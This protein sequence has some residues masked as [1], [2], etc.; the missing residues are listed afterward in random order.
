[1]V[2]QK[3]EVKCSRLVAPQQRNPDL[4][5]ER[6]HCPNHP[7]RQRTNKT[8]ERPRKEQTPS[9]KKAEQQREQSKQT[10]AAG[11][12]A[13]HLSSQQ[14]LFLSIPN[15]TSLPFRSACC[16]TSS[17]VCDACCDKSKVWV[18]LEAL[19]RRSAVEM[20]SLTASPLHAGLV[21]GAKRVP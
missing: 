3:E 7:D 17:K 1:V 8:R 12:R 11:G 21:L 9:T 19:I 2:D 15:H 10:R 4:Y 18:G 5:T 6:P 13:S 14:T 20:G 16:N